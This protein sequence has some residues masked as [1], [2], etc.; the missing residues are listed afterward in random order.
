MTGYASYTEDGEVH[1]FFYRKRL[2]LPVKAGA[3][4]VEGDSTDST[5]GADEE[6]LDI[7]DKATPFVLPRAD[8]SEFDLQSVLGR[9]NIIVTTYRAHW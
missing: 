3:D 4:A 2:E 6:L 5:W 7:G 1:D 9:K 8:G